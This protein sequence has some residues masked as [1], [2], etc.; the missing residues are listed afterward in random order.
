MRPQLTNYLSNHYEPR[1]SIAHL[2][3][4]AKYS[5]NIKNNASSVEK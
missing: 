4:G 1:I 3:T 2:K 5:F